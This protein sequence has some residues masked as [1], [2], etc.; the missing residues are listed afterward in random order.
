[1]TIKEKAISILRTPRALLALLALAAPLAGAPRAEAGW[2]PGVKLTT[3]PAAVTT[4]R[5]GFAN[6]NNGE[7]LAVGAPDA[8]V[9]N[10]NGAGAVYLFKK[11]GDDWIALNKLEVPTTL[12]GSIAFAQFGTSI[13]ISR[14][15]MVVGAWGYPGPTG[16]VF[17]G[18]AFVYV[19][20]AGTDTW[21]LKAKLQP[22]DATSIDQ[23]GWSVSV[24]VDGTGTGAIAVGRILEGNANKGAVHIFEG[25]GET[26]TEKVKLAPA[27]LGTS[28]QFGISVSIRGNTMVAGTQKHAT[29]GTNAGAAYVFVNSGGTWGQTAKLQSPDIAAGDAFG[30]SVSLGDG[31]LAVGAPG[32]AV[33]G[34]TGTGSAYIFEGSGATWTP[35]TVAAR[36]PNQND[37]FGYSVAVQ[38]PDSGSPVPLVVVGCPGYDSGNPNNGAAFVFKK[39]A[40]AWVLDDTDLFAATA[41]TSSAL[42][43]SVSI[44]ASGTRTAISSESPPSSTGAAYGFAL[45]GSGGAQSPGAGGTGGNTG[46][47]IPGGG[48][49]PTGIDTGGG[50]TGGGGGG[51]GGPTPATQLPALQAPFG[52]VVG[53]LILVD[54]VSRTIMALQTNGVHDNNKPK[55]DIIDTYPDNVELIA[56][57]DLNGDGS[58]DLLFHNS[59]NGELSVW[60]RDG[61]SV[62]SKNTIGTPTDGYC[63]CGY[64]DFNNDSIDDLLFRNPSNGDLVVWTMGGGEIFQED[65]IDLPDNNWVPVQIDVTA[66]DHPDLMIRQPVSGELVQ[67]NVNLGA[68]PTFVKWPDAA[69]DYEL[70][71]AGDMD[72][73]GAVDLVWR[74]DDQYETWF[75]DSNRLE[76][77]RSRLTLPADAWRIEKILDF[78]GNGKGDLLISRNRTG[79]LVVVYMDYD[80]WP[81]IIKSR[82]LGELDGG[83]NV[84]DFAQR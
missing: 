9:N 80:K 23:F 83:V 46:G 45:L 42:G 7:Y 13:A 75:L 11:S 26:W 65:T 24:D 25:S 3:F 57:P 60:I 2:V 72:G 43:R 18:A 48:K 69:G 66:D 55:V 47:T 35:V 53:T 81:K 33:G 36:A 71:A 30:A 40:A 38:R 82:F 39:P 31:V 74:V 78:D 51:G 17:S 56:A 68:E 4:E 50:G 76:R 58:G 1:M 12:L 54:P 61:L 22:A 41:A 15:T 59:G 29:P 21:E 19:R 8:R 44:D 77:Q 34:V 84:I 37:A 14:D 73:D 64:G 27:D 63:W 16:Q 67:V 20:A 28:D 52:T 32:K 49:P 6:A 70:A 79:R 62:V 10:Q 5:F